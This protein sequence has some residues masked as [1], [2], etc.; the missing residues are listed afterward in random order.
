MLYRVKPDSTSEAADLSGMFAGESVFL[1]APGPSLRDANLALLDQR[2]IVTLGINNSYLTCRPNIWLG[3]DHPDCFPRLGYQ[4]PGVIK[5][6]CRGI[7]H[8][9]VRGRQLCEYPNIYFLH[10]APVPYGAG[11]L[12]E[13]PARWYP[14]CFI[15]AVQLCWWLGFTTIY[16]VGTDFHITSSRQYS[17]G[18]PLSRFWVNTNKGVYDNT[19]TILRR[20]VP[21]LQSRGVQL[22]NTTPQSR[23]D[24]VPHVPLSDAVQAVLDGKDVDMHGRPLRHAMELRS[25]RER[26]RTAR[27][28]PPSPGDRARDLQRAFLSG[29]DHA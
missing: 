2:G 17:W 5:I 21:D 6:S 15:I 16:T 13:E 9:K 24:F 8:V 23:L 25:I 20:M 22:I 18:N 19:L 1:V 11:S 26:R 10:M 4:D 28:R 29:K 3:V 7:A 12:F 14:K 27:R